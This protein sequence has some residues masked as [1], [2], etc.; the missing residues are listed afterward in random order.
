MQRIAFTMKIKP[1]SEQEYRRRHQQVWPELLAEDRPGYGFSLCAPRGVSSRLN[2]V[3]IPAE[4]QVN[5][6]RLCTCLCDVVRS[7]NR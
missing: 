3:E 7:M 6:D 1:G 2:T 4:K 5:I